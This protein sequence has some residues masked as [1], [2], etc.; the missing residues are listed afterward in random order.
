MMAGVARASTETCY[1][2]PGIKIYIVMKRPGSARTYLF[3]SFSSS[4]LFALAF[5]AMSVYEVSTAALNPFQL[6]LVGTVLEISVFLCEIPTG[7]VADVYSRRLSILIGHILIGVG[8]LVEGSIPS[9][10]PILLA[11]VLWGAGYT[12]TSGATEAWVSDEIGEARANR[13]FLTAN[14]QG[15][16]GSLV[17]LLAAILLGIFLPTGKLILISGAGRILLA[18]LLAFL[19]TENGYRP[20]RPQQ[21]S[22]WR[23][24]AD[25]LRKGFR[26]VR[27]RPS[28]LSI[29]GV[30]LFYGLYS[31]GFDR[32][33]VRHLLNSFNL[34]GIFAQDQVVFFSLLGVISTLISMTVMAVVEKRLDLQGTRPLGRLML[35]ITAGI[36]VALLIFSWVPLLSVALGA[37][38]LIEALR[39]LAAP[40]T[41]AWVNRRLDPHVRAT[42]LSLT[43]QV[44]SFGQIAGGPAIGLLGSAFSVPLA[45]SVS[46]LLLTPAIGFIL[47]ANRQPQPRGSRD[48]A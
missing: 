24:L 4:A 11:Q 8:F 38:L 42:I 13:A 48:S 43:S 12:F 9:F 35:L 10:L 7:I 45:I 23:Q 27:L 34:P 29:L 19:M 3:L 37:Y 22:N 20:V 41:N 16:F 6:V 31:E 36:S 18:I 21:R 1:A 26:T 47:R 5:T 14:R 32:L 25:T 17:G 15:L 28:L 39:N 44:D 40:L 30:G 2:I 46:A 33:W